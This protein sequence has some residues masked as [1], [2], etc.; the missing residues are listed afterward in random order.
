[1]QAL[2]DIHTFVDGLVSSDEVVAEDDLPPV[3]GPDEDALVPRSF[4]LPAQLDRG[5]EELARCEESP[6]RRW[7]E[8]IRRS[9]TRRRWPPVEAGK[10]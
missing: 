5:L 6:S 8:G 10:R 2:R 7:S 1:M 9:S 4:K 3:A